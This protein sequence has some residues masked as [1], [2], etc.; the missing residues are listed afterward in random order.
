MVYVSAGQKETKTDWPITEGLT[1]KTEKQTGK[2]MNL[3]P[4]DSTVQEQ[5][6]VGL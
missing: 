3:V 2:V 6:K 1:A 5:E 4:E